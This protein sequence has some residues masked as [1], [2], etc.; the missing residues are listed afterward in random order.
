MIIR[1][2]ARKGNRNPAEPA[3]RAKGEADRREQGPAHSWLA[4]RARRDRCYAGFSKCRRTV[5]SAS[6]AVRL[7]ISVR[8]PDQLNDVEVTP[9]A[10][11]RPT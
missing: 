10:H 9:P 7:W 5:F 6:F 11:A 2:H 1:W 4:P 8:V 3:A